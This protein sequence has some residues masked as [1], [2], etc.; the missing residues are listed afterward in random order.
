MQSGN[1]QVCHK[2]LMIN[3]LKAELAECRLALENEKAKSELNVEKNHLLKLYRDEL[4]DADKTILKQEQKIV[5][6]HEQMKSFTVDIE[7]N[8][9]RSNKELFPCC[10]HTL[11]FTCV[12]RLINK[13]GTIKCPFDRTPTKLQGVDIERGLPRNYAVL[14]MCT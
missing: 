9:K 6:L 1:K 10:G 11:C 13:E 5:K 7:M 14:N 3:Q 2:D 4:S 12:E 8:K